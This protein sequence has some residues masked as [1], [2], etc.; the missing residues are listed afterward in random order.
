MF[1]AISPEN[2][3][4]FWICAVDKPVDNVENS[5]NDLKKMQI[6]FVYVNQI[7]C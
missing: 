5:K 2:P 4:F 7:I 6:I 1:F 3:L